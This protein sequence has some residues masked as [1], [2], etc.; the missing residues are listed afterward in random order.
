MTVLRNLFVIANNF[1]FTIY[2]PSLFHKY[3]KIRPILLNK[4]FTSSTLSG[5]MVACKSNDNFTGDAAL[6]M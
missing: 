3:N 6:G 5:Q 4:T 2:M 1:F